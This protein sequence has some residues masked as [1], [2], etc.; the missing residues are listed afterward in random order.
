M[1]RPTVLWIVGIASDAAAR[2]GEG[3]TY[4]CNDGSRWRQVAPGY[5]PGTGEVVGYVSG[6]RIFP[7]A[8]NP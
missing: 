1:T 2:A 6:D 5:Q 3:L 7:R 8:P 4:D